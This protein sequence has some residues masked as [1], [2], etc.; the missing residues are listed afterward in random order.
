LPTLRGKIA[1]AVFVFFLLLSRSA[2]LICPVAGAFSAGAVGFCVGLPAGI[3]LSLWAH[4]S[5]GLR[6]R[7]LTQGFVVRMLE[8]GNND[9][10]KLLESL[11]ERLHGYSLTPRQCR[12]IV[13]AYA[14]AT[15]RLQ[16]CDS[17]AE[18]DGILRERDRKVF[19]VAYGRQRDA[20]SASES[21]ELATM[22][23]RG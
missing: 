4:R 9:R 8:R 13:A 17:R 7:N 1:D 10:P 6:R 11:V 12:M 21:D 18:R 15:R 16:T 3:L 22:E 2:F 23:E 19:D 14:E 5:L 20:E